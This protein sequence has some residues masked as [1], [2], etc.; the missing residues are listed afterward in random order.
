[1][2]LSVSSAPRQLSDGNTA[3]TVLGKSVTDLISFYGVTPVAQP[4]GPIEAAVGAADAGGSIATFSSNQTPASIATITTAEVSFTVAG[5]T[6]NWKVSSTDL[7]YVN[8]PTAQA[9]LGIGNIR[10]SS[11]NV[12]GVT[13]SNLSAG[14]L[15]P[16]AAQNYGIVAL[17]GFGVLTQTLTP[18]AVAADTVAEQQFAVI[19]LEAGQLVQ[20]NK[21]TSQ[22]GLDIAGCRVVSNNVLGISFMNTTAGTLTPT[23]AESY[24][25]VALGG[26]DASNNNIL[27]QVSG[28]TIAGIATVTTAQVNVTISGLATTDTVV[29]IS[30]PTLQAGLMTGGGRVSAAGFVGIDFVNP[31]GGTLTPTANE[32]YDVMIFRPSP[33]APLVVF[34][35]TLT[36][37]SIASNTT[38]EQG[39]TVTTPNALVASSPVWVNKP[40]ITPGLG[41]AGVRVS[42]A[43]TLAINFA[44]PTAAA[45]TPPSETYIIGNFQ[46]P[47]DASGN[48][49][50]QTASLVGQ[51]ATVLADA[52]RSSLVSLG[53]IAGA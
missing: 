6:A 52:L 22:A 30:K 4:S 23:A 47:I 49:V 7:L 33:V 35:Q 45:I 32:V 26:V 46:M 38:A 17:R 31:T 20:V 39:F 40:S 25:V 43:N 3:G 27:Y 34:S 18:A 9:G 28:G 14:F 10:Y 5:T 12:A 21:P 41:I 48:S 36:P 37:V 16:T 8:K 19:G 44:N 51:Q 50:I 2:P 53:L 15:T 24:S 1:M 42:A 11:S 29:G 13:F